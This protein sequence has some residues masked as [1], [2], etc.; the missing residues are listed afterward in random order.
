MVNRDNENLILVKELEKR[1]AGVNE[2]F[3]FYI[4]VETVY[5]SSVKALVEA[6]ITTVSNNANHK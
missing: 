6:Q 2:L 1:E 5:A 4:G 3:D